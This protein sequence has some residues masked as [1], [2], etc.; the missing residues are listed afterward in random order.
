[1]SYTR[2]DNYIWPSG[3]QVHLWIADGEDGGAE[4]GWSE[5]RSPADCPVPGGV[6]V[7]P[8]VDDLIE[9]AGPVALRA[10][11]RYSQPSP[12]RSRPRERGRLGRHI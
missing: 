3:D 8:S 7:P 10:A 11:G 6:A 5:G 4:L 2:G 9:R 12:R 1:M